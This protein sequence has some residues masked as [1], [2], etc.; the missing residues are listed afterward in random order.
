MSLQCKATVLVVAITMAVTV[1][2]SGFLLNSSVDLLR[3]QHD[4]RLTQL[5]AMLARSLAGPLTEHDLPTLTTLVGDA[6]NGAPLAYVILSDA[7]GDK[8]TSAWHQSAAGLEQLVQRTRER[9]PVTGAPAFHQMRSQVPAFLDIV[10]PVT[11]RDSAHT[12]SDVER[13]S[14]LVGY[15]RAG[16]IAQGWQ[17]TLASK[18]DLLIGV[19][20]IV[21]MVAIPLGFVV[22][23]R[24]VAPMGSLETAMERFSLGDFN[25]R[26][27]VERRDEIGRL[28]L[29]F[30]RMA[31]QHQQT[32]E[33]IVRLNLDLESRVAQRTRQLREL[34]VREPLTGLYN[35]RHFG[36]M[37]E[38]CF[39]EA[40]RYGHDLSCIMM[41]LDDFK[42]VNDT[43]G[44]HV[45]D[46]M[47]MVMARTINS[48]LR[49]SDVPARYGGDE[50]I[51]LLPQTGAA[52]AQV[53]SERIMEKFSKDMAERLPQVHVGMSIGISSLRSVEAPSADAVIR[54]ADRSLYRAKAAGKN[55][56]VMA[57][58]EPLPASA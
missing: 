24:I 30:N 53:L 35:R 25:V 57:G 16:V 58:E 12:D 37:L 8:V 20:L 11:V 27:R 52:R 14:N 36:E 38:R 48:Q 6:V 33:R 1:A 9:P 41:D 34:A 26:S 23:R 3:E 42:G 4:E 5:A 32:H 39:A 29:A 22:V 21:T 10:Y 28:A 19:G 49:T 43:C 54:A 31:D 40:S 15:I 55:C 18:L 50:F 56:I 46:E 17:Q 2:A 13:M 44:H 47:L 45:G 7:N 51:I